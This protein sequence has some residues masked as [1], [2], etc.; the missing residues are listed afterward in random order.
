MNSREDSGRVRDSR[1]PDGWSPPVPA[2][3]FRADGPVVIAYYAVQCADG[4]GDEQVEHFKV[5]LESSARGP[6]GPDRIER[7]QFV[8]ADGYSHWVA[9]LYWHGD[10]ERPGRW[11]SS[12]AH[13]RWW[14]S[15]ERVDDRIGVFREIYQTTDA[16][17]ET[18]Y[19][20]SDIEAGIGGVDSRRDGPI[21]EHNYWGAMR[22]RI[23]E[24]RADPLA[25][26]P[27]AAVS[28]TEIRGPGRRV[29]L[30]GLAGVTV[31]H[32]GQ[33]LEHMGT[34]ERAF[35]RR[36]ILPALK[37]GM[38]YLRDH[39]T[40][41]GCYS[42]RFITE[43]DGDGQP[44]DRTYGLAVFASMAHLEDWA[45]HHPTHLRIYDSFLVMAE[46]LQG[47][48]DI[49]LWHQVMVPSATS[50]YF[51]YINCHARTGMLPFAE[52]A[53]F[54]ERDDSVSGE[55]RAE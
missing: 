46:S 10:T 9:T 8:D 30:S 35:Y 38:R 50:Q 23:R 21:R 31:I 54:A 18:L 26:S 44:M 52:F 53:E 47:Q 48:V 33:H 17:I 49:R 2:Y 29:R 40:D 43:T 41:A 51:E 3:T 13:R 12:D 20:T 34:E 22:D 7:G 15:Q 19:S 42:A 4:L 28:P 32:S 6:D 39:P 36:R 14:D 16:R 27:A 25:P 37:G 45:E 5:W 11:Q 1:M 24:S 55:P